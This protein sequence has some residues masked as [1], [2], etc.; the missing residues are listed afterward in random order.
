MRFLVD[1][2]L[3]P[4]LAVGLNEAGRDAVHVADLGMNRSTDIE[5]LEVGDRGD[6][7]VISLDTDSGRCWRWATDDA[8]SVATAFG[9]PEPNG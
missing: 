4:G 2:N 5:I 7:V 6:R 9:E 8:L 3:S 1:A